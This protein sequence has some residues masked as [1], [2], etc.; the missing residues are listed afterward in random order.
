M[1]K[2][3]FKKGETPYKFG[4]CSCPDCDGSA[5]IRARERRKILKRIHEKE[6]MEE[7]EARRDGE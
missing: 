1:S 4:F 7:V 6:M 3:K 2:T 5:E